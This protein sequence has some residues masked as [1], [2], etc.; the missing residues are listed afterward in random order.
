MFLL[1]IAPRAYNLAD[2]TASKN[3]DIAEVSE[4]LKKIKDGATSSTNS[5]SEVLRLCLRL[6]K[7]LGNDQLSS[8]ALAELNGY[9]DTKGLPDYR[10]QGTQV[11]G[12]FSG[13]FRSGLRNAQI[14]RMSIDEEHRDALFTNYLMDPVAELEELTSGDKGQS[15]RSPWSADVIAYYQRKQIYENM[16]LNAAWREMSKSSLTG[17]LDT[18]RTRVLEFALSIEEELHIKSKK[19]DKETETKLPTEE[20]LAQIVHNTIYGGNVAIGNIGDTTQQSITVQPG[21]FASLKKYLKEL[22]MTDALLGELDNALEKDEKSKAQPGPAISSWLSRVM[23]MIG[24][25]TLSVA[26]NAA[27]SLVATA[28]MQYLGVRTA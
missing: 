7:Q 8:W 3:I 10:V 14:P 5:L 23:I 6:G 9:K 19:K 28:I 15:L 12:H 17:A 26:S 25:G 27:G 13:P 20:R 1:S 24:R 4:L 11:L 21:D 22:G 2:M 16:V 18:I